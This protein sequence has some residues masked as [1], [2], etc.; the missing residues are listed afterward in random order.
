[1]LHLICYLVL[2]PGAPGAQWSMSVV[3]N[4]SAGSLVTTNVLN[5][6]YRAWLFRLPPRFRSQNNYRNE[7]YI[8][9]QCRVKKGGGE[10]CNK[11][12]FGNWPNFERSPNFAGFESAH[13]HHLSLETPS[14][15]YWFS[16]RL[17]QNLNLN[18]MYSNP[19]LS[20]HSIQYIVQSNILSWF[21]D[22]RGV[23]ILKQ[24]RPGPAGSG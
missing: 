17:Q 20:K 12:H 15:I 23:E 11:A 13:Q 22:Q 1:M 6:T 4:F 14:K 7:K 24:G 3:N 18:L 19:L 5:A 2:R 8:F 21:P 10:C 16:T 9:L